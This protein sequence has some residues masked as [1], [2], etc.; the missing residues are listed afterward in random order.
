MRADKIYYQRDSI[1]EA[2]PP[3]KLIDVIEEEAAE[4]IQAISKVKRAMDESG[5]N[6]TDIPLND[7][8]TQA[9][10]EYTDLCLAIEILNRSANIAYADES[11]VKSLWMNHALYNQKLDRWYQRLVKSGA[12]KEGGAAGCN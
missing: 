4:F 10:G 9:R 5:Q 3:E 8:W 11:F 6:P 2:V 1:A 7:A 12:I